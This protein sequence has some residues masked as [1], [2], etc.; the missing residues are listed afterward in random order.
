MRAPAER[1]AAREWDRAPA[2]KRR[3]PASVNDTRK[4]APARDALK[5]ADRLAADARFPSAPLTLDVDET[6]RDLRVSRRH[7]EAMDHDGR[8]GPRAIRLGRRRVWLRAE[9]AQWLA[10]GAPDRV[11]WIALRDRAE[12]RP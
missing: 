5:P 10:A 12:V 11:T 6:A 8:L 7:V 2:E 3:P 9:I 4:V 1:A